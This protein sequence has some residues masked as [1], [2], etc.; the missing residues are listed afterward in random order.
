[1]LNI[2][3]VTVKRHQIYWLFFSLLLPFC[4]YSFIGVPSNLLF[5]VTNYVVIFTASALL[6]VRAS[7]PF[8]LEKMAY[9]FCLFFMGVIPV[10]DFV[11]GNLYWG[12]EPLSSQTLIL[13]NVLI[14]I[15]LFF[16]WLG[17]Q[18]SYFFYKFTGQ[19]ALKYFKV[20][21]SNFGL[22]RIFTLFVFILL[23]CYLIFKAADFN[24]L[25]LFFRGVVTED[26][27]A[28]ASQ[29]IWLFQEYYIR[30]MPMIFL[31][32]YSVYYHKSE[33]NVSQKM[34]Y[35]LLFL[36]AFTFVSPT[37]VARF[38]V[39][40]LYI[41]ILLA[42]TPI[43]NRN[44]SM[45]LSILIALLLIFP[46]L[47]KFRYFDPDRFDFSMD[48]SFLN[49]GHF[50][51]Y[52]NFTR[53]VE[54]DLITCGNQLLGALLFFVPRSI[55]SDKPVGSGAFLAENASFYFSNVS[56]PFFAE[57]YINFGVVGI[58]IFCLVFGCLV[59]LFDRRFWAG[60]KNDVFSRYYFMLFGLVFFMMRGDLL[61]SYSFLVGFTLSFFSVLLFYRLIFLKYVF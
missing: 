3:S 61:S 4:I 7:M 24:F 26:G 23:V 48:F 16:L 49:V 52:Q 28:P 50:D 34:F 11:N 15:S 38:M 39:A 2:D 43:W 22:T 17:A 10:S 36:L 18:A 60:Q 1:M 54:M 45:P 46:F 55:W 27:S 29:I 6:S 20:D 32:I 25:K 19:I 53:I 44:Y 42:F 8:S 51:A 14:T 12:G 47:D 41:P 30:P 5:V 9:L 37:S 58:A 56:M 33:K 59:S 35:V 13:T 57:G 40:A 31:L 21:A